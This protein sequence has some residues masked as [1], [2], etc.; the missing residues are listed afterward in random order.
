M[1]V[2]FPKTRELSAD[3][4]VEI[5]LRFNGTDIFYD[6][7]VESGEDIGDPIDDNSSGVDVRSSHLLMIVAFFAAIFKL[8]G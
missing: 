7:T 4:E 1:P 5:E 2:G 3:G 6:P 8:V